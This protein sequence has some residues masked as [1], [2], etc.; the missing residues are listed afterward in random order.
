LSTNGIVAQTVTGGTGD[1]TLTAAG[2]SD[3]LLG[4]EGDDTLVAG[5]LAQLTG[6]AGADTFDMTNVTTNVNSY[7]TV[8]DAI[9]GDIIE[10]SGVAFNAGI[11]IA[12]TVVFQDYANAAINVNDADN[13]LSWF[14]FSGNTYVVQD[15]D[16]SDT[17]FTNG[18][19]IVIQLTGLVDLSAASFNATLGTIEI[20]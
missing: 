12:N 14:Q 18:A 19:D 7:A 3:V 15:V 6:G 4:G 9:A 16:N 8:V 20:A 1:D 10:T 11:T 2:T 5:D 17:D 13:T